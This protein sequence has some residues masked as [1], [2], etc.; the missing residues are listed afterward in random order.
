MPVNI[1]TVNLRGVT[2]KNVFRETTTEQDITVPT[3]EFLD[4]VT[5]GEPKQ[6]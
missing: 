3:E 4:K 5:I 6:H 1:F 2:L